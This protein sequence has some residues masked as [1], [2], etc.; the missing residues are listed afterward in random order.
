[1]ASVTPDLRL[2]S[3]SQN[4]AAPRLVPNYTVWRQRHVCEQLAQGRYLTAEWLGVELVTS[5]VASQ[6]PNHY[7][8][9]PHNGYTPGKISRVYYTRK[10][11]GLLVHMYNTRKLISQPIS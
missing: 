5:Q 3:Q 1:M 4:I 10:L 7:T 6:R 9:R 2:R 11:A 8:D